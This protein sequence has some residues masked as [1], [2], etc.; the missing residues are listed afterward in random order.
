LLTLSGFLAFSY[1]K[2]NYRRSVAPEM[3]TVLWEIEK[4]LWLAILGFWTELGYPT[5]R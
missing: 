3:A 2:L 1:F 5:H 4:S